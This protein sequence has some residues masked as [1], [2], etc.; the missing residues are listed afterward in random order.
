MPAR[1]DER[2]N[3]YDYE[4]CIVK[5]T[6]D[7]NDIAE[8]AYDALGRRIKKVDS[9]AGTTNIY[10]YND[11]WQVLCDYYDPGYLPYWY[12][13]GNYI[14]EVLITAQTTTLS[15][16]KFY[17]HD[18]LFSP[19]ALAKW[20]GVVERYEYDAYGNCYILEPNF[21]PDPDGK[22]DYGNPY[23]FTASRVDILDNGS[24]KIQYNRNRYYDQYTGRWLT[25]DPLG[26]TPNSQKPNSFA[27]HDQLIEGG[28]LYEYVKCN[29]II[30]VDPYGLGRKDCCHGEVKRYQIKIRIKGKWKW[31]V[32]TLFYYS[33]YQPD[34]RACTSCC[35][36]A[37]K[38]Y[39]SDVSPWHYLWT[40]KRKLEACYILCSAGRRPWA[41]YIR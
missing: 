39:R 4:N 25:H 35:D 12:A 28:N 3:E 22:S 1:Q 36:R 24:L 37:N 31:R 23:L 20:S 21:A 8:F 15:N 9:I 40:Y 11:K 19:V 2:A 34:E 33:G 26:I 41:K 10:Y 16:L 7:G 27:P 17:V 13:Y 14:D 29:P 5:I 18:H 32:I 38:M 30:A 6:K